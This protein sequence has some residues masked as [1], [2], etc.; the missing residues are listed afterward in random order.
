MDKA[1]DEKSNDKP[2]ALGCCMRKC[3]TLDCQEKC[4]TSFNSF[5]KEN[6]ST[7]NGAL[8]FMILL[9]IVWILN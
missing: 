1:C 7:R 6:F 2:A 3:P 9:L 8:P 4:I 5:I